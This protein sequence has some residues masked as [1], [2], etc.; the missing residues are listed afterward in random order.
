[1]AAKEVGEG[2]AVEAVVVGDVLGRGVEESA[3]VIGVVA[4]V[5]EAGPAE[6]MGEASALFQEFQERCRVDVMLSVVSSS[7]CHWSEEPVATAWSVVVDGAVDVVGYRLQV[8]LVDV[9]TQEEP[10]IELVCGSPPDTTEY[11]EVIVVHSVELFLALP[12]LYTEPS[13]LTQK[14]SRSLTQALAHTW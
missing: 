11:D 6:E 1:M 12:S 2:D 13:T 9:A 3:E 4:L 5:M 10:V 8:S 7:S 14:Q